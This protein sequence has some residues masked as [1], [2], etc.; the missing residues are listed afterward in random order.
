MDDIEKELREKYADQHAK[1][2][3]SFKAN[4]KD[5]AKFIKFLEA[6][7]RSKF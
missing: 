6:N 1:I 7:Y 3:E 4:Q 2:E 5:P